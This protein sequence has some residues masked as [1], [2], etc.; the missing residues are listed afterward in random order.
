MT[1]EGYLLDTSIASLAVDGQNRYNAAVR[2]HLAGLG[3][4]TLFVCVFTIGEIEY[5]LAVSTKIDPTRHS[6]ARAAL[7]EYE[8]L[9]V[10]HHTA[11]EFGRIRAALFKQYSPH[12]H[13]G[14][15]TTKV[16]EDLREPTTAKE[17]GIQ[18]NDLWIVSVAV[19]YDVRLLTA[20]KAEGMRRVLVAAGYLDRTDFFTRPEPD[21]PPPQTP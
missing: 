16:P 4:S 18:E 20:D 1:T 12:D 8:V 13:R 19:Q 7:A 5:G 15:L 17:L 11:R 6:E 14:R 21:A 2:G 9:P 10:D 3:D